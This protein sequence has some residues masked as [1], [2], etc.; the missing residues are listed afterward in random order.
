V[1]RR[2]SKLLIRQSFQNARNAEES[3]AC[4]RAHF[5]GSVNLSP[6]VD[7]VRSCTWA[8]LEANGRGLAAVPSQSN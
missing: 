3:P 4:I 1:A 7:G 5:F 8:L 2:V 6:L